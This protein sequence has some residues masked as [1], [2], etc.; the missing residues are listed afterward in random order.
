[1]NFDQI[2]FVPA[3]QQAL[4]TMQYT[5]LTPIQEAII[6]RLLQH[7]D[8]IVQSKT[9]S[10]KTLAY[11]LPVLQNITFESF[12]P[13]ALILVPTRELA[14]QVTRTFNSLGLYLHT[15]HQMLIGKQS[16]CDQRDDLKRRTHVVI[17]TPGRLLQHIN[18]QTIDLS[19]ISCLILDEADEMF[20]L[21][22]RTTLEKILA[23]LPHSI[24][25]CCLS[26][27]FPE[28]IK[29][30]IDQHFP[31]AKW[32][33]HDAQTIPQQLHQQ[34]FL[35]EETQRF[36]ALLDLL[37]AHPI[38][39]CIIFVNTIEQAQ[40]LSD[41]LQSLQLLACP[42]HG[43]QTQ[44]ERFASLQHFKDGNMRILVASNVAARG[45]DIFD[46]SLIVNYDFPLTIQAYIHRVGRTA[47]MEKEGLAVSFLTKGQRSLFE[48]LQQTFPSLSLSKAVFSKTYSLDALR[49]PLKKKEQREDLL[50]AN[51][52]KL[53]IFAGKSK[54]IRPGDL[55]GALCSIDG[56]TKEDI[57]VIKVQEHNSYVDILNGK[58][59]LAFEELQNRTIKNKHIRVEYAKQ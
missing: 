46:V 2:E 11:A 45:L 42:L 49:I 27:T 18:E 25:T 20:H 7:Q 36:S 8:L 47:R 53:C 50:F 28:E 41:Q 30:F 9:G 4:Q 3:L 24:Q 51:V 22:F 13:Q 31:S 52:T 55:L 48:Q 29:C 17:A 23:T 39:R 6:P 56:I 54:K 34:F 15:H 14:Q 59:T 5:T 44:E 10:G 1:M 12:T 33:Q 57:G 40:T 21:G 32:I 37:Q 35:M 26:A 58:G 43:K 16:F 19:K 38:Q